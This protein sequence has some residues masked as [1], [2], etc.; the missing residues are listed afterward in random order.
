MSSNM[1][2]NWQ[3]ILSIMLTICSLLMFVVAREGRFINSSFSVVA[4]WLALGHS[5]NCLTG[6]PAISPQKNYLD[7][8]LTS[9]GFPSKLRVTGL[10]EGNSP[11][12]G[13]LPSQRACNTENVSIWW[14]HHALTT[15]HYW[16]SVTTSTV[17]FMNKTGSIMWISF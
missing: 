3:Y 4:T 15:S 16:H 11:G 14:C 9:A 13:E 6:C 7:F 8:P 1:Q 5:Y 17:I 12:T 2:C 10:C